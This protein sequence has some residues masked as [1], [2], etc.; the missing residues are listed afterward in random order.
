MF[1]NEYI[2]GCDVELYCPH[3][4]L[5]RAETA[6]LLD[7]ILDPPATT[8]D[9]FTDDDGH[10]AEAVLNRLAAANILR[11]CGPTSACPNEAVTRG[12]LAALLRRSLAIPSSDVD[13]FVDD[14]G[15]IF[16]DDINAI[17]AIGITRGCRDTT[18]HYCPSES[19]YRD[20]A[21]TLLTRAVRWWRSDN[22]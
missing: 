1:Q 2:Y 13:Q 5:T 10:W 18:D 8:T 3:H 21:A 22:Q 19:V 15:N 9:Y 20:Q 11:G 17:A 16:E 14:N 4:E 12:Q 7:R 6:A